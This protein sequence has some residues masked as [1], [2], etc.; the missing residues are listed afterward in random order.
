LDRDGCLLRRSEDIGFLGIVPDVKLH[1]MDVYLS[2]YRQW[3]FVESTSRN[4]SYDG[5]KRDSDD[6]ST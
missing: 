4:S 6:E 5:K 2:T 1:G 3:K